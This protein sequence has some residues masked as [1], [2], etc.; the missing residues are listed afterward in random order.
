MKISLLED[1]HA[2]REAFVRRHLLSWE[3]FQRVHK[4]FIA[5][6]AERNHRAYDEKTYERSVLWDRLSEAHRR[7]SF[8]EA[9]Q[10]LGKKGGEVFFLSEGDSYPYSCELL[11]EGKKIKNFIARADAAELASLAEK[12]WYDTYHLFAQGRYDP[13]SI[14]PEDLYVFDVDLKDLIVFTHE[15]E[16]LDDTMQA[17]NSRWCFISAPVENE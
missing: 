1:T 6:Y 10:Y 8:A 4:D 15:A 17:A 12:E 2:L 5:E 3:E 13:C 16:D 11:Y 7:V 14:L 9:L